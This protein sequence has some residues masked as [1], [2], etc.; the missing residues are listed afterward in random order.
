MAVCQAEAAITD[1]RS[2]EL[3][4]QRQH[5]SVLSQAHETVSK[6]L[7]QYKNQVAMMVSARTC[8]VGFGEHNRELTC[9]HRTSSWSRRT[10]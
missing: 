7:F 8:A 3:A 10:L 2:A 9:V 4:A 5:E 6:E 1:M